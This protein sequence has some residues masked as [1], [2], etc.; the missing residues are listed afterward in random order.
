MR[1]KQITFLLCGLIGGLISASLGALSLVF[2][3]Y[4]VG[5]LFFVATVTGIAITSAWCHVT[6][7]F[8]R[9]VAG[10]LLTTTMYV[11]ALAVF[12]GVAGFSP[13][14]FGLR[15]S[16]NILEFRIDVWLGLI[17]A[18]VVA[19]SGIS[20]LTALLVGT[21]STS[22]LVRLISAAL[23]TIVTTFIT[24]L[25]FHTYWSF[26]GVL[27][28][29]GDALFCWL[30]GRQIWLNRKAATHVATTALTA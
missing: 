18:G 9:Y 6:V 19:A 2:V 4:G 21:W 20:G 30:V 13:D 24:N 5:L 8:L 22:L 7:S 12:S 1:R 10:L 29:L 11:A 23:L 16:A 25:S 17:A 28:P 14:W 26:L 3:A 27:L 15:P